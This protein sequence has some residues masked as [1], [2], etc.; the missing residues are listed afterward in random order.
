[1]LL[2]SIVQTSAR[3]ASTRSRTAKVDELTQTLLEAQRH[4][5]VGLAASYLSGTLPQR[6]T[7]VGY[8]SL[9]DLPAPAETP[10]LTLREV[11]EAI[12]TLAEQSGPGSAT[13]RAT[14][15]GQLFGR[16][17]AAEAAYLSGLLTGEV[18]QGALDGLMLQA[19]A[20]A[21][22]V[23]EAQVRRAVTLA[24]FTVPV[25]EA[26]LNSGAEGL[27]QIRLEVGRPLRPMLASSAADIPAA[28]AETG[29]VGLEYKIDGIRLQIHIQ[30]GAVAL[31]TR[32][33]E[34]VTARMP[35]IVEAAR[36]WQLCSAVVDAEAVVMQQG[37]P[38]PFQV[39]GSRTASQSDPELLRAHSPLHG[40]LFDLLHLNGQ[41]LLERPAAERFAALATLAPADQLVP[42]IVT[43]QVER[44]QEFFD[45][46]V[47]DGFEGVVV[48]D[49]GATYASGRRGSGWVKVKPRHTLDLVVVAV[50]WGSG[51][52]QGYLSNIHLAAR[53]QD[54]FVMLGKTFKGMTDE[55]LAWQT[56]R[57]LELE[58]GRDGYVVQVRPEQVV[59]VAFD[60][61]QTSRRYPAGLALRFARVLRYRQDKSAAEA[62]TIDSV[63]RLAGR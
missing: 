47:A 49:L 36:G 43:S 15:L 29:E 42:R 6:R 57:F 13:R 27:A 11:D 48:K 19:I 3:I 44:A 35:E 38:A 10:S 63:R 37:R 9:N 25:A 54:G 55:M 7:G 32:T 58:T 50:E 30:D 51:R 31:F 5:V 62:D 21:A 56:A 17:T 14:L 4:G 45:T 12:T 22:G 61:L 23:S 24:G 34:D 28:M 33:L 46:A 39:T 8:R 26:A 41:D 20:R 52:R 18:R 2:T 1:M 16:A 59:E 40:Y 60:G 53:D